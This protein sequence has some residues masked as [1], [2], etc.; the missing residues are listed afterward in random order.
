MSDDY[1]YTVFDEKWI[2]SDDIENS[3]MRKETFYANAIRS[4]IFDCDLGEKNKIS[5]LRFVSLQAC[6][7]PDVMNRMLRRA[8]DLGVFI[9]KFND[10]SNSD[11]KNGLSKFGIFNGDADIIISELKNISSE[12]LIAECQNL[13]EL[14]P[15]SHELPIQDAILAEDKIFSLLSG[16]EVRL[17]SAPVDNYFILGD[18]PLEQSNLSAGFYLPLSKKYAIAAAQSCCASPVI[19]PDICTLNVLDAINKQQFDNAL[20]HVVGPCKAQ[21]EKYIN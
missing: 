15:Q 11:F 3:L 1:L 2:P 21:L 20:Q 13:H 19:I 7:H 4:I 5:I 14:S 8:R 12:Q 9:S 6:R 18:T 10:L 17:L 16:M